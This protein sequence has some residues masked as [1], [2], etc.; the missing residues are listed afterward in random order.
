MRPSELWSITWPLAAFYFDRAL[1]NWATLVDRRIEEAEAAVRIQMKNRRGTD[2]FALQA[3]QVAFNKLVGLPVDSA[4]AAPP[5]KG[6]SEAGKKK[7]LERLSA[8]KVLDAEGRKIDL[9]RFNS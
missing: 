3:R 7:N 2:G 6:T 8:P 9:S 4:Y 5:V 1:R